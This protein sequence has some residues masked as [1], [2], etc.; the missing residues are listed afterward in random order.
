MEQAEVYEKFVELL[1]ELLDIS[2]EKIL[3]ESHF[4]NDLQADSI[5]MVDLNM[6]IEEVFDVRVPDDAQEKIE[7][8][9]DAVA[10]I[11][12]K[13]KTAESKKE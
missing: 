4:L 2:K 7:T 5:D 10:F 6:Q 9:K 13:L 12:E 3:P 8:V 1:S 11:M